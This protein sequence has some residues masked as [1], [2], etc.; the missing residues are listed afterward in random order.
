VSTEEIIYG[1]AV[2]AI[3]HQERS[4][5]ELR[6]RAGVV[7][8]ATALI[9]SFLGARALTGGH[10]LGG[11]GKAGAATSA[12]SALFALAILM[13]T[14]GWIF[15]ND[16]LVLLEDHSKAP[17]TPEADYAFIAECLGKHRQ[18][19]EVRLDHLYWA[20]R[21]AIVLLVVAV[22]AWLIELGGR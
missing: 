9:T 12:L 10:D 8:G 6:S 15:A 18:K 20:L 4:V 14:R 5:D 17:T 11:W 13:P 16:V 3:Q 19:N 2:R 21:F 7:L 1:E 22:V